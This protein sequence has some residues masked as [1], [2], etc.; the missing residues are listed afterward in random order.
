VTA[1]PRFTDVQ[2]GK[3][4]EIL[5]SATSAR[6][7]TSEDLGN[8]LGLDDFEGNWKARDLI[9]EVMRRKRQPIVARATGKARGYWIPETREEVNEYIHDLNQR[10]LGN[11]GRAALL[12]VLWH[13]KHPEE[14]S[15]SGRTLEDY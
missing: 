8:K 14:D 1:K 7:V 12:D 15:D 11:L 10:A 13:E 6:P 9:S 4:L 5:R 3:A 2:V